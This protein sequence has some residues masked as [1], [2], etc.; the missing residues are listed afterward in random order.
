MTSITQNINTIDSKDIYWININCDCIKN[1][2][3]GIYDNGDVYQDSYE[4]KISDIKNI[5]IDDR[6]K[7]KIKKKYK[8]KKKSDINKINNFIEKLIYND[9][10]IYYMSRLLQHVYA[11]PLEEVFDMKVV[12]AISQKYVIQHDKNNNELIYNIRIGLCPED[13]NKKIKQFCNIKL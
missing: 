3:H 4:I 12:Y 10:Y 1:G 6:L 11:Y 5:N 7:Q 8:I 2:V 13:D 9:F